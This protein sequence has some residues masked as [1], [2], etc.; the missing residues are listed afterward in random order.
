MQ[1]YEF[2]KDSYFWL[3]W[4]KIIATIPITTI[5]ITAT[6]TTTIQGITNSL[7]KVKQVTSD[8]AV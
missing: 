4:I 2:I 6:T 8:D 3:I 7:V 1:V 5:T